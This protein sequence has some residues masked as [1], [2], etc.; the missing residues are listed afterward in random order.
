[1]KRQPDG[2]QT[3]DANAV[4]RASGGNLASQAHAAEFVRNAA[5]F[6]IAVDGPETERFQTERGVGT[7]GQ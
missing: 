4:D 7:E 6:T 2:C 5:I 1:M 3:D